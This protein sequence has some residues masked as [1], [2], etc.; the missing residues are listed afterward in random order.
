[1][2]QVAVQEAGLL[3]TSLIRSHRNI[4]VAGCNIFVYQPE[5]L[6]E[7]MISR[8]IILINTLRWL[9]NYKVRELAD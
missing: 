8:T 6:G 4:S 7:C 5:I 1:M 3:L 2:L 9:T